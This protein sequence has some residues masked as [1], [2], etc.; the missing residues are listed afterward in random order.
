MRHGGLGQTAPIMPA[1][2]EQVS[3]GEAVSGVPRLEPAL[4][5]AARASFL[6]GLPSAA[7]DRVVGAAVVEDGESRAVL[8]RAGEAPKTLH[9]VLEG[10]VSLFGLATEALCGIEPETLAMR[11]EQAKKL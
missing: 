9:L 3:E 4:R 5:R 7:L 1:S 2:V 8:F 11:E 10:S 6:G